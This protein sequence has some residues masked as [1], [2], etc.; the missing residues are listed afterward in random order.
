MENKPTK[1]TNPC[2]HFEG[3]E[4]KYEMEHLRVSMRYNSWFCEDCNH[5]LNDHANKGDPLPIAPS[6]PHR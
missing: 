6:G 1:V 2:K 4:E 3:S 5:W